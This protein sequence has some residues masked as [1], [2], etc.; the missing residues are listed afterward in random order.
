MNVL[1]QVSI[2]FGEFCL[3]TLYPL[4]QA[5]I[6]V[7][8]DDKAPTCQEHETGNTGKRIPL[9]GDSIIKVQEFC[10]RCGEALLGEACAHAGVLN[11]I[12]DQGAYA[13]KGFI[14]G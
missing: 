12:R 8:Y 5:D 7:A 14:H 2:Q 4:Q 3:Q 13:E 1:N 6:L 9:I 10:I 11:L